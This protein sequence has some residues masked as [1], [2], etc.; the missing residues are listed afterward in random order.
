MSDSVDTITLKLGDLATDKVPATPATPAPA[1][2][3]PKQT[4]K[5]EEKKEEEEEETNLIKSTH[6]V[7]VKLADQQADPNSPLYSVKSFEQLGLSPELL[8]GIYA[9]KFSKPSKI[10]ERALPLLLGNPPKNMIGQSQSGTG[11]TAAFVLTMLSR[12]NMGLNVPQAICLAPSRELARQIMD[13]VQKMGQFTNVTTKLV[14]KDSLK[15][16]EPVHAQIVV[17]TPGSVGDAIKRRHLPVQAVKIFVLDEADNML[18][19]DGLGDQSIRIKNQLKG[20]PQI[21]LFSATFPEHVARFASKFAPNANEI[22]LKREDL[23]VDA[24]KQLYMDCD[25][26]EHKYETLCNIYNLLTVSQSIIFCRYRDSAD[27]I[28]RRMIAQGH[29]VYALH[30]KMTPEERD[31]VMDDFRRGV[32]KVLITT[33]V[34]ARGIDISQVSLVINYDLPTDQNGQIDFEAYLHRIGRTGRFGRTG[35]SVIL[36]DSKTSWEQM[37]EIENHFGRPITYVPT[38]DWEAV[39][40]QLKSII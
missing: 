31:R 39:E 18:D 34:L 7:Q 1:Q 5:P 3:E 37:R 9:M 14:V 28:A 26:Q 30:G 33:N 20:N 12:I 16:N 24:I 40:K 27:E 19:Q 23:S 29:T 38:E 4:T 10:Q 6:V 35:V 22:T 13:V 21:V 25:S 17:G 2:N 8:K 11:K 32:F 15:R 36:I